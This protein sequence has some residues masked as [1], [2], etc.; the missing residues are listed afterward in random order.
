MVSISPWLALHVARV[1]GLFQRD[2]FLTPDEVKGLMGGLL[3]SRSPASG[4]VRLTQWAAQHRA[5]LGCRYA[6]EMQR[7][8]ERDASYAT[9]F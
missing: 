3:E 7:R 5:T 2:V 8:R 4:A 1:V 9:T 6:N